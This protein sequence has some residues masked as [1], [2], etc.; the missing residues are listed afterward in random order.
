MEEQKNPKYADIILGAVE[1][2]YGPQNT[3]MLW[4]FIITGTKEHF[5]DHIH[6]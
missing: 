5:E 6:P 1:G 4:Q 3:S 2:V